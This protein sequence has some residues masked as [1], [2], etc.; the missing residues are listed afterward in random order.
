LQ[1]TEVASFDNPVDFR[2]RYLL[3]SQRVLKPSQR[4]DVPRSQ[5][6]RMR[7]LNE[8]RLDVPGLTQIG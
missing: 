2:L 3:S 6:L 1:T 4:L 8:S 5:L 7:L